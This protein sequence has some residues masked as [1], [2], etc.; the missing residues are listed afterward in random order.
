MG[1][2]QID[3][4]IPAFEEVRRLSKVAD[5][6]HRRAEAIAAQCGDGIEAERSSGKTRARSAV[7]TTTPRGMIRNA[8]RNT[9]LSNINAGRR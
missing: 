4:N 1:K 5:E 2:V 9:I 7:V 6:L 8:K 3:W